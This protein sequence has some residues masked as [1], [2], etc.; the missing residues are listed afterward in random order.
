MCHSRVVHVFMTSLAHNTTSTILL[1][2]TPAL[3]QLTPNLLQVTPSLLQLMPNLL[4]LTPSLLQGPPGEQG[5]QGAVGPDGD[6]GV[7]VRIACLH[8]YLCMCTTCKTY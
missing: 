5:A 4:Q 7:P 6:V 8:V 3:L 2:L 1:Q